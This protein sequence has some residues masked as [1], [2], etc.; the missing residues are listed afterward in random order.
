MLLQRIAGALAIGEILLQGVIAA[1]TKVAQPVRAILDLRTD[2]LKDVAALRRGLGVLQGRDSPLSFEKVDCRGF[3]CVRRILR[4]Q[5]AV[6]EACAQ[7]LRPSLECLRSCAMPVLTDISNG[8]IQQVFH[9]P[10]RRVTRQLV[11]H[12]HPVVGNLTDL[13]RLR[14]A[15]HGLERLKRMA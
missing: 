10:V 2:G 5:R 3:E 11:V 9:T 15:H 14:V 13:V 4:V 6:L 7:H 1:S 12:V 8:P